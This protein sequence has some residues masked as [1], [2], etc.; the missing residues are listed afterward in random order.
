MKIPKVLINF[1]YGLVIASLLIAC[2]SKTP[3]SAD[4]KNYA[5][6]WVAS[7]GTFVH[8]F[9]DGSG[10]FKGSNSSV[11]GGATSISGDTITIALGPVKQTF[12]IDEPPKGSGEQLTMKLNG[13]V[14]AK[15]N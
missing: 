1:L 15:Q 13:I 7:D 4:Q 12:Q 11:K 9:L 2:V 10:D 5:G 6:Q 8:I 3:L 14:Y